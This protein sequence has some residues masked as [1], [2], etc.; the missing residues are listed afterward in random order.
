M[1]KRTKRS[2]LTQV[3]MVI[4]VQWTWQCCE[5]LLCWFQIHRWHWSHAAGSFSL[6]SY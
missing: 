6:V 3:G 4:L 1:E 5:E 2:Q